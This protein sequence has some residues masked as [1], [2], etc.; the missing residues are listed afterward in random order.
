MD[1]RT[2]PLALYCVPQDLLRERDN[3]ELAL[4]MIIKSTMNIVKDNKI[5]R[6]PLQDQY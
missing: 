5:Q 1:E 4:R 2:N 6:V 3:M